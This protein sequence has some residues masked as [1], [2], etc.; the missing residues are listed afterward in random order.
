[1][2]ASDAKVA[3]RQREERG[4]VCVQAAVIVAFDDFPGMIGVCDRSKVFF[5]FDVHFACSPFLAFD[6]SG[7]DSADDIAL[8]DDIED[9]DR[10]DGHDKTRESQ[11]PL[12]IE[13][14]EEVERR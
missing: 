2:S 12:N 11:V 3:V 4:I 14:A 7:H 9:D 1:M 10:N 6:C 13:L 8:G 5:M